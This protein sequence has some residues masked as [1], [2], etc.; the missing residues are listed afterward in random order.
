MS[1]RTAS[2]KLL[3]SFHARDTLWEAFSRQAENMDCSIDYLINEAMRAYA[4][5]HQFLQP[6]QDESVK[7]ETE[8]DKESKVDELPDDNKNILEDN[9][10]DELPKLDS[11]DTELPPIGMDDDE[12]LAALDD[13][14]DTDDDLLGLDLSDEKE[15]GP[16]PPSETAPTLA[17]SENTKPAP[18]SPSSPSVPPPPPPPSPTGAPSPRSSAP[19]PLPANA[20]ATPGH[21][22]PAAPPVPPRGI[23]PP[24]PPKA[25][26]AVSSASQAGS[27]IAMP[28][29]TP[30]SVSV[31]RP[32]TNT[33]P[34]KPIL[35][36]IYQGRKI[37]IQKDQFIIGRGSKSADMPIKDPNV[38]R[39]HAA[40]IFHNGT[41]YIK[42]LG[43]TNGVEYGGQLV[44]S[45]RID[46]GDSFSI[47][48]H[49]FHFTYS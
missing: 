22:P 17:T 10:A 41:Y 4:E 48:G 36:M 15:S 2:Q 23:A 13:D 24:S 32:V 18:P 12:D 14:D 9:T 40:I 31:A 21:L 7:L 35:T 37:L 3:Q 20:T 47:C 45:K 49:P 43:S 1:T 33:N 30:G 26:R 27:G 25:V 16:P 28:P 46:E 38:S 5:S 11:S 44:D 8:T 42:D 34:A 29:S 39:K 19:P 6:Q